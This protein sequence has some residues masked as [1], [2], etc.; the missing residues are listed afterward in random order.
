MAISMLSLMGCQFLNKDQARKIESLLK[1]KYDEDFIV[2]SIG[3]RYGTADNDTVTAYCHP[4]SNDRITFTAVMN[5]SE[6]LVSDDYLHMK[7]AG[8]L[9][10]ELD[11]L[12]EKYHLSICSDA[13][14]RIYSE[15]ISIEDISADILS[16]PQIAV[17]ATFAVNKNKD[18]SEICEGLLS[19]MEDLKNDYHMTRF[20]T[21]IY[22]ISDDE[23]SRCAEEMR[24]VP[25][26]NKTF[27]E[28][29]EIEGY[30]VLRINEEHVSQT[31][32]ELMTS[33]GGEK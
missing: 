11:R 17:T 12:Y 32:S 29:Y 3:Q 26:V 16:D 30:T 15:N 21:Q 31:Y 22:L 5:T 23:Y 14:V 19:V 10:N 27:F 2:V 6:E 20:G 24:K 9:E 4:T 7:I 13:S 1:E 25:S 8:I 28:E 33:L 18:L